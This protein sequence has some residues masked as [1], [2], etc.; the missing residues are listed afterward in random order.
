MRRRISMKKITII[1]IAL[2]LLLTSCAP[3]VKKEEIIQA[4]ENNEQGQASIVPSYQLSKEHYKPVLPFRPS[5]ARGVIVRQVANRLDIDEMEKGLRRLSM[6]HFDTEKYLYD[7][8][9]YLSEKTV[10]SLIDEL[11]PKRS[12][13]WS[14]EEHRKNPR[15]LSHILEQ[16]YVEKIDGTVEL[17]GV[18]VAI[19]LKSVYRFETATAG[20]YFEPISKELMLER[21]KE[22]AQ[23]I[24]EKLRGFE[25]VQSVPIMIALFQEEEQSSPVPGNFVAK[26]FVQGSDMLI[27]D[28]EE[29]K[30]ENVLFPS[31]Y[32]RENYSDTNTVLQEFGQ[33]IA[34]YFP[35][36]VGY[37]GHGFYVDKDLKRLKIKIPIEFNG[38]SEIVGFTQYVYGL[39]KS[40]FT[41]KYDI[42]VTIESSRQIESIIFQ[43]VGDEEPTAHILH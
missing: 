17:A 7:E 16:N 19:A 24:L 8:G 3:E 2:L 13:E 40:S 10:L 11:N 9:Q 31:D 18:S 23:T 43:Q 29:V 36:Y 41:G 35:N 12:K 32:A 1:F 27:G 33:K 22:I 14:E 25:D 6:E 28:W 38:S 20:P 15:I 26:T 21:G 5:A 37:V 42:E 34:D 4:E 39:V 30:E